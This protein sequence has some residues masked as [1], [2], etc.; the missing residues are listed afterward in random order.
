MFY[1]FS[2]LTSRSLFRVC[3]RVYVVLLC[4][5][6]FWFFSR[7]L[8]FS[9]SQS[10]PHKQS[11]LYIF[12]DRVCLPWVGCCHRKRVKLRRR[13]DSDGMETYPAKMGVNRIFPLGKTGM[14]VCEIHNSTNFRALI[15]F[16]QQCD[17]L[18]YI[19]FWLKGFTCLMQQ[20]DCL[21]E[22]EK[23]LIKIY[24]SYSKL[25]CFLARI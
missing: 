14:F 5:L 20:F 16:K 21:F 25:N 6:L 17:G 18:L 8:L 9:I 3:E 24:L 15:Q 22:Y 13:N 2:M 12:I 19:I 11:V 4:E 7:T 23:S 1:E 10:G